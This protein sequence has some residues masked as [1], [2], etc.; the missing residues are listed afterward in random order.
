MS[1]V[2]DRAQLPGTLADA[3][4]A[5]WVMRA[6]AEGADGFAAELILLSDTALGEEIAFGATDDAAAGATSA[7]PSKIDLV[8]DVSLPITVELG[9]A[10]MQIQDILKLAPGSVIELDKSA[11]DPVELYIN[12]RRIARGEVVVIDE[13]FGV[14]LT[15]IVTASERLKT[16]R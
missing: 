16:L 12:D 7:G 6:H 10:R 15:G 14:R 8:L 1:L 3:G 4:G 11:G 13:S 2:A 9:R 5:L